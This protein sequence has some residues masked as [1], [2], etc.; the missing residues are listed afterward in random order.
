MISSRTGKLLATESVNRKKQ[1]SHRE[2]V[3]CQLVLVIV[4]MLLLAE[5]VLVVA[6]VMVR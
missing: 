2:K 5:P 4:V 1:R 6:M 3:W